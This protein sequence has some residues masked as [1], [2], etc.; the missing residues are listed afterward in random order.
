MQLLLFGVRGE[1]VL[2]RLREME[3]E[4]RRQCDHEMDVFISRLP[5]FMLGPVLLLLFPAFLILLLGP[6]LDQFLKGLG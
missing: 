4:I 1:S 5:L 3:I 2:P 6:L